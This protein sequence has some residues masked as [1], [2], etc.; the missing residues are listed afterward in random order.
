MKKIFIGVL[1]LVA[2]SSC[3]EKRFG[4][5]VV[6]GKIENTAAEKIYLEE[7][8]FG[9]DN[10]VVLDS[11]TLN[12]KGTF[13]LRAIGKEEGLYLIAVQNGPEVLIIN[14]NNSIKK[15]RTAS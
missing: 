12:K 14:D 13:E 9:G 5:F 3:K 1:A 6:A 7:L 8:P 15:N 2:M 10:P 11:A 4:A